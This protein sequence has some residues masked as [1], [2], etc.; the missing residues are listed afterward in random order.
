[1]AEKI[2]EGRVSKVMKNSNVMKVPKDKT[3]AMLVDVVEDENEDVDV[4]GE[5]RL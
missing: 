3:K 5:I 4:D 1:M 2:G